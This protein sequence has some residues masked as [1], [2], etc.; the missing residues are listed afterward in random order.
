MTDSTNLP[1]LYGEKVL[2]EVGA[3]GVTTISEDD[4]ARELAENRDLP[5]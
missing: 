1:R 2:A 4:V 5:K 3:C